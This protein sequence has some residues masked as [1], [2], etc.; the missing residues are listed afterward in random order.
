[1]E[2]K[3]VYRIL[4][5]YNTNMNDLKISIITPTYNRKEI[6][7]TSNLRVLEGNLIINFE[8]III[9]D[10]STEVRINLFKNMSMTI[11]YGISEIITIWGLGTIV[12]LILQI[13]WTIYNF[14]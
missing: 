8:M 7:G 13:R 3:I 1:M 6:V 5:E 10:C 9:D 4:G 2:Y 11:E 14:S 12:I